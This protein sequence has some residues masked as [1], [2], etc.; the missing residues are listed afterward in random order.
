ME[1]VLLL[2]R[3]LL[4]GIFALA[5]VAKFIDL[6]GSEKAALGGRYLRFRTG[7]EGAKTSKRMG[8]TFVAECRSASEANRERK[9]G[10]WNTNTMAEAL[11]ETPQRMTKTDIWNTK[12]ERTDDVARSAGRFDPAF[13]G[14]AGAERG[15]SAG[16]LN[17]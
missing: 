13:A 4:A 16:S 14:G 2:V 10:E 6:K 5:G 15:E 8:R 9:T 17:F 3:I 1:I 12:H 7:D 11:V